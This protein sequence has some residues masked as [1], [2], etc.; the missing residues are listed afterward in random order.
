MQRVFLSY[1]YN[2]HPDYAGETTSL[3]RHARVV[4]ESLDL[5]VADGVD[6]GGRA[7]DTEIEQRITDA[8]ALI[9]ILTPQEGSGNQASLPPYVE[10]EYQFARNGNKQAI[11]ILHEALQV[12]G[13]YQN[14]EFILHRADSEVQTLL[15]L[16]RTLAVWRRQSGRAIEIEIEPSEL[17]ERYEQGSF[18][19]RCEYQLLKV[20]HCYS[21]WE[22]A[23]LWQEPGSTFAYLPKVPDDSKIRLRLSLGNEQWESA[24]SN[25]TGRIILD[26]A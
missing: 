5:R 8:D 10:N 25:P 20:D 9:A 11:R 16:M 19:H 7:I 15:K 14:D 1:T 12:Q 2:P 23:T 17:G 6:L 21:Q 26:R 22:N 3:E 4:I 18:G 13:M 24:F